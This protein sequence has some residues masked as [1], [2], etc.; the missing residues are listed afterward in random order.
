[1]PSISAT[2]HDRPRAFPALLPIGRAARVVLLALVAFAFVKGAIWGTT[3][4]SIWGPDEDYHFLYADGIADEARIID[5][6][7]PLYSDEY[8]ITAARTKFDEYGQG[9]RQSFFGHPKFVLRGLDALPPEARVQRTEGRGIGVVHPPLYHLVAAGAA[10]TVDSEPLPTRMYAMRVASAAFGA[11][12]VYASWLLAAQLL[13]VA[14]SLLVAFLVA[15]QPMLGYYS[16]L[17]NHDIALVAAFTLSLAMLAFM[18][19]TPPR[20]KQGAVLGACIA[21]AM[22]IKA[23]AGVLI[24]FAALVFALQAWRHRAWRDAIRSGLVAAGVVAVL[25]GWWYVRSRIVYGSFTGVV[26]REGLPEPQLTPV[27]ADA[28]QFYFWTRDWLGYAYKTAFFH[29]EALEAPRGRWYYFLPAGMLSLGVAGAL[30]FCLARGRAALQRV[31]ARPFQIVLLLAAAAS[32]VLPFLLRDLVRI[33]DG[34]GGFLNNNARYGLPGYPALVVVAV[35]GGRYLLNPP[36]R[37]L[38]GAAT[39][40]VATW[41]CWNIWRGEFVNRYFNAGPLED[42]L[43][44]MTWDRPEFITVPTLTAML[45]VAGALLL[46]AA[47]ASLGPRFPQRLRAGAP[48][49]A[50]GPRG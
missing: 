48:A 37:R 4:P 46:V 47:V 27:N 20:A 16:G 42:Q 25:A 1:V 41:F 14:A 24:F 11:L 23:S 44:F 40:L 34:W 8:A 32:L 13:G 21:A 33:N 15:V 18:L 5:P 49:A 39:A 45:Y 30:A 36:V 12:A 31:D 6:D 43:R 10:K 22:L 38:A 50:S 3:T 19:R 35:L 9:P 17:V 2:Q 26:I 7:R 28:K 29:F